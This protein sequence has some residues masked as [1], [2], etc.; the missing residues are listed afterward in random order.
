MMVEWFWQD[1]VNNIVFMAIIIWAQSVSCVVLCSERNNLLVY[2]GF[3]RIVVAPLF[4]T[5]DLLT[6]PVAIE[7]ILFK[8][9]LVSSNSVS[10]IFKCFVKETL[11]ADGTKKLQL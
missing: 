9:M 11:F 8:S 3:W 10:T 4:F 1:N 6:A 5:D 2:F 7:A